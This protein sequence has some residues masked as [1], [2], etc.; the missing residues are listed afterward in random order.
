MR[1]GGGHVD[2][3]DDDW[4]C[5][6]ARGLAVQFVLMPEQPSLRPL[7]RRPP[8]SPYRGAPHRTLT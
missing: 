8:G 7:H 2:Q 6:T 1:G 4:V 3:A 5:R